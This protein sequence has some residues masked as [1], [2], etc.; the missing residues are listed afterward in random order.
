[1]PYAEH[2][3][4][5]DGII[6]HLAVSVAAIADPIV[7]G[8]YTGFAAVSGVT[9][10]ELA[11]K[12]VFEEFT[13]KKHK[14]FGFFCSAYFDRINGKIKLK[15]IQEDYLPRFGEK[16]VKRFGRLLSDVEVRELRDSG[17]SVKASYGNLITWRN[18]F[19]HEGR[20]PTNATFPEVQRSY[21]TGKKVIECLALTMSR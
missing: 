14:V 3:V 7:L 13:T 5:A 12:T 8:Q 11:I 4:S 20:V 19:A 2:F 21:E 17:T 15:V 18:E 1:M 10:Y 16:Y 9:V 6:G